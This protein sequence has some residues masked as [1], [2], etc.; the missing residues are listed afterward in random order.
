[1]IIFNYSHRAFTI[2][3]SVVTKNSD[4]A[5]PRTLLIGLGCE[6]KAKFNVC[7]LDSITSYRLDPSRLL[8][9]R[10]RSVLVSLELN[11]SFFLFLLSVQSIITSCTKKRHDGRVYRQSKV[12]D[13][14]PPLLRDLILCIRTRHQPVPMFVIYLREAIQQAA[15]QDAALPA[16]LQFP[17]S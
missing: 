10:L 11:P 3:T 6:G 4:R 15:V 1:L 7:R 9:R 8:Y 17:L 5:C 16:L 13:T 14:A 2:S 12:I